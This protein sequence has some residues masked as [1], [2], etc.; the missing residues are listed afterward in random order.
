MAPQTNVKLCAVNG[1]APTR[2]HIADRTYPLTAPVYV[3]VRSDLPAGSTALYLRD[4][5]R[6]TEGQAVVDES[7]YVPIR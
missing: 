2:D 7:G 5:L 4:W 3:V 6:S 1:I